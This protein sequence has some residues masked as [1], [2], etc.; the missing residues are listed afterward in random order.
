M[1][2][3]KDFPILSAQPSKEDQT[4]IPHHLY[5]F[6]DIQ[7]DFNV[8]KWVK[9]ASEKIKDCWERQTTPI[10]VGGTGFYIQAMLKG[11]SPIPDI[12]NTE[13]QKIKDRLDQE[14]VQSLYADLEIKDPNLAKQLKPKDI[15]RICRA[16][17]VFEYTG[18][19]LSYWQTLP[20]KKSIEADF[21]LIEIQKERKKLYKDI[22]DRV[23]NMIKNGALEE[24]MNVHEQYPEIIYAGQKILGY[25]EIRNTLQGD[26]TL[27]Q[28]TEKL[29]QHT[30]N[31]AK[32]QMTWFRHQITADIIV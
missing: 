31:Y 20:K 23:L 13:R 6:L 15:Q 18:T 16:L 3:Y 30:R 5:G 2:I 4:K 19:P 14:G 32:R 26:W 25:K 24:V 12:P 28:A 22:N 9:Q 29:Q 21:T 1:Q 27:A 17:E 8:N 7:E 10:L 11:L